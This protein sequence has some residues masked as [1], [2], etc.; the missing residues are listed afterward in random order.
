MT[1]FKEAL[2]E[3]VVF[4]FAQSPEACVNALMSAILRLDEFIEK[5]GLGDK[6]D[7]YFV[8]LNKEFE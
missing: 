8:E 1:D 7:A 6:A 5:E 2:K 3:L 4:M